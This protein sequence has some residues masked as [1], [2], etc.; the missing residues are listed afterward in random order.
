MVSYTS[1]SLGFLLVNK[2]CCHG[3]LSMARFRLGAWDW[4]LVSIFLS[5]VPIITSSRGYQ[6]RH[7]HCMLKTS[8]FKTCDSL[9]LF[10]V[11]GHIQFITLQ[12]KNP[13]NPHI[14][15]PWWGSRKTQTGPS[16]SI[17]EHPKSINFPLYPLSNYRCSMGNG[18]LLAFSPTSITAQIRSIHL[19]VHVG[20]TITF[21]YK[22]RAFLLVCS[23]L[24][25]FQFWQ[26]LNTYNMLNLPF[27]L[28]N[29]VLLTTILNS[30]TTNNNVILAI[31]IKIPQPSQ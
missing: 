13:S 14:Y 26:L 19:L 9:I 27:M 4:G 8:L 20:K 15:S 17:I 3:K 23:H 1:T 18:Q 2:T 22:W 5:I 30:L 21:E 28:Q 11:V 24:L 10:T 7:G 29:V 25:S 16:V 6:P 12:N 31:Q